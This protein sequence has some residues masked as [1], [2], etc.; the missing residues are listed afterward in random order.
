MADTSASDW[1][2][3]DDI[4]DDD[5]LTGAESGDDEND[6]SDAPTA[7]G[8]APDTPTADAPDAT[9]APDEDDEDADTPSVVAPAPPATDAPAAPTADTAPPAPTEPA[10]TPSAPFVLKSH[11][12]TVTL[13]GITA[14]ATGLSVA[15][16]SVDRV[17]DLLQRGVAYEADA[18]PKIQRLQK[19]LQTAQSTRSAREAHADTIMKSIDAILDG[20]P[21]KVAEFF[22]DYWNNRAR[23]KAEA[24]LAEAN[25]VR[26]QTQREYEPDPEEYRDHLVQQAQHAVS[27]HLTGYVTELGGLPPEDIAALT[28]R[29][30]QR[31]HLFVVQAPVD[32]PEIGVVRGQPVVDFRALRLEAEHDITLRRERLA[33]RQRADAAEAKRAESE[34]KAKERQAAQRN[35]QR[36]GTATTQQR[37]TE[38]ANPKAAAATRGGPTSMADLLTSLDED[39]E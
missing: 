1:L 28:Q 20:G 21:E 7:S 24:I 36:L 4:D 29:Y 27:E 26:A 12:K 22:E 30:Q 34:R 18:L 33:E 5:A 31:A 13:D 11:G 3:F 6:Q 35:A 38:R 2:N 37:A 9:D 16:T 17:R 39:D 15:A 23:L 14:T 8:A 25:E 32:M 10:A 19:D